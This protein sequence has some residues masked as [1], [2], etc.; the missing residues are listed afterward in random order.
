MVWRVFAGDVQ[1]CADEL[2]ELIERIHGELGSDFE[3]WLVGDLVNRGPES[4]R[5]LARV[6]RLHDSGRAR[7]VLGNHEIGLLRTAWGMRALAPDD[8]FGAL[9][10]EPDRDDWLDWVRTWP[11]AATG[12][13]GRRRFAMVHAAVAPDWTLAALEAR[14]RAVAVRLADSRASAA[15][16]IG[17]R[18]DD[19][20]ESA[21]LARVTRCRSVD[22]RGVWSSR[23]P[24]RPGD[25]WH[26]RWADAGHDYGIVYGHWS[27]Q[28]LHVARD[29]RGLD[30]GCV[31][32]GHGRDGF[33]TAWLPEPDDRDPFSVP[34]DRFWQ[35]PARR[36]YWAGP[37][38]R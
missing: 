37:P 19:D 7:V 23:P 38:E 6:R 3:L 8:T 33:L 4:R 32:H 20:D 30:T 13:L 36:R 11:L 29:L 16:L 35:I 2:D 34:D 21:T 26:R 28:G 14:A 18:P 27:A 15:A 1:G 9:L 12:W 24:V 17:A 5:V 10:A 31:Y 22:G 25:A